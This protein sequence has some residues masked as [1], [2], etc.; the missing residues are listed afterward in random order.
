MSYTIKRKAMNST[1][2]I[3]IG[4]VTL[5]VL[6]VS[7]AT[8]IG[9]KSKNPPPVPTVDELPTTGSPAEKPSKDRPVSPSPTPSPTES[10]DGP[11]QSPSD[12]KPVIDPSIKPEYY[13]PASGSVFKGYS[14]DLPVFSLTMNDYRAHT[15][16][17]ISADIGSAVVSMTDGTVCNV[18]NDPMM[19]MCISVDHGEGLISHYKNLSSELPEGIAVGAAVKAGQTIGAVGDSCLVELAETE[20][21]HFELTKEGKHLDPMAY[22]EGVSGK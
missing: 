3:V 12:D 22:L 16:I 5:A 8:A 1:V 14:M 7:V 4:L 20:H 11:T 19:G 10:P 9:M 2:Y 17:D 21:L 13:L 6:L 18:W 15:G